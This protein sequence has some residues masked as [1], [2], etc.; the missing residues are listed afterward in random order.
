VQVAAPAPAPD[1]SELSCVPAATADVREVPPTTAGAQALAVHTWDA[2]PLRRHRVWATVTA[3]NDGDEP[4]TV[5]PIREIDAGSD[6]AARSMR[7]LAGVR[8]EPH[9][10]GV[11]T[12]SF[13]VPQAAHAVAIHVWR[14][15]AQDS[16]AYVAPDRDGM[17]ADIARAGAGGGVHVTWA[18]RCSAA[19]FAPGEVPEP[20]HALLV[21]A[22]QL[23]AQR[24]LVP[25]ADPERALRDVLRE[26]TGAQRAQDLVEVIRYQMFLLHDRHSYF[27]PPG[28]VGAFYASLKPR[29]PEV[30]MRP[31]GIAVLRLFTVGS[32]SQDE[33]VAYARGLRA[34]I[35]DVAARHPRAW[36]VDLRGHGGGNMWAGLAGITSL[37]HGPKVGAFVNRAGTTTWVAERG[38]AGLEGNAIVD[39]QQPAEEPFDGPVA[40]LIGPGTASSGEAIAVAFEGRPRTRVFGAPTMGDTNNGVATH[41]LSDGTV[42]GIAES[43]NADRTGHVREGAILPDVATDT[44]ADDP[45]PP[46]AAIEWLLKQAGAPAG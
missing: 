35:A 25:P 24:A 29:A 40:V 13:Y 20:A 17:R 1:A 26:A 23:Y 42:F 31:D 6:V 7:S 9:G 45:A 8:L 22:M 4:M 2:T 12:F 34:G 18:A 33:L 32:P 11:M 41:V 5:Y 10:S 27:Y 43:R 46:Q 3:T 15:A 19:T 21:E 28:D 14:L 38:E 16:L 37:L 36:I 30:Q 39:T 44:P